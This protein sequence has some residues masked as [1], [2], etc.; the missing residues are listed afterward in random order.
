MARCSS[1]GG[2]VDAGVASCPHC[3]AATGASEGP[4]PGEGTGDPHSDR[5]PADRGATP[6]APGGRRSDAGQR[7]QTPRQE[8]SAG[9]DGGQSTGFGRRRLLV[10]GGGLVGLGG[11][12][13]Y[14]FLR[15]DSPDSPLEVVERSWS[16]WADG[17]VTAYQELFH[18]DSP[19]RRQEYWSDPEYWA[20]LGPGE[21][22]D[23]TIEEREVVDRTAT[24]ATVREVYLWDTPDETVRITETVE[25]RTAGGDWKIWRF[26]E[27]DI[28][29]VE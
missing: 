20:Q 5:E 2:Q 18:P 9:D 19:E 14:L 6:P 3:G 10:A 24:G 12:G 13:W 23:W 21:G 25:L 27:P 26:Q 17:D 7:P 15:D 16:T 8:R 1:C 29:P 11:A 4:A 28:E 22:V